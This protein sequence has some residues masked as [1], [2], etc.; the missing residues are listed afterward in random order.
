MN[1]IELF[2]K[3]PDEI[4]ARDWLESVRWPNGRYCGHCGSFDT[5]HVNNE[6]PMR[7]RCRDCGNYFSVRTNTVMQASK[8]PLQKWVIAV[9]LMTIVNKGISSVQMG[10][11]LGCTQPTAWLLMQKIREGWNLGIDPVDGTCEIDEVYIGGK[12]KNKHADKKLRAG[13]GMV[14]K[15][16]VVG[17]AQRDG[18]VH[19]EPVGRTT[20]VALTDFAV[21]TIQEG[22][23]V[24]TDEHKGYGNLGLLYSHDFVSH[25]ARQYVDGD[26]HTN[27]IESFWAKLRRSYY[28]VYHWWSKKHLHRYVNEIVGRHNDRGLEPLDRMKAL[29]RGMEGRTLTYQALVQ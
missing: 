7:F 3:F 24:Y 6:K 11:V 20:M 8:L 12:E 9:Y 14:G 18:V 13:R 22:A 26:C 4:S 19:A 15:I 28:G 5:Y 27:T 29:V 1:L 10:K 16:P 23:T 2:T 17:V 21:R 25:G